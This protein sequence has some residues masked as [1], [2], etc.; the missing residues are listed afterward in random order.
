MAKKKSNLVRPLAPEEI[1]A[2]SYVVVLDEIHEYLPCC[3][4][5]VTPPS[6]PVRIRWLPDDPEPL[7]VLS[8]CMPFVFAKKPDDSLVTLDVRRH[9][10]G[11]IDKATLRR[12]LE[13]LRTKRQ[14]QGKEQSKEPTS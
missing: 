4:G 5:G 3:F 14:E 1:K 2:G 10:L 12:V 6:E 9:Q 11:R 8:V 13:H 7:E